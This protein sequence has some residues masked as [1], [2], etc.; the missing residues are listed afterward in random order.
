MSGLDVKDAWAD[1]L[2]RR[3]SLAPSLTAYTEL[4]ERWAD[5][6]LS[7]VP[8]AWAPSE[9]RA[10]WDR[11]IPLLAEANP[12]LDTEEVEALLGPTL[13]SIAGLR[14]GLAPGL[15]RFAE[16]WDRGAIAPATLFPRRGRLGS[17]GDEVG[18][19][20]D[21]LGFLAL[22]ALRPF[23][24]VYFSE[25][26]THLDDGVW[27]LGVCPFCGAPPGFGD[28]VEDGRR[29]LSCH[30]CGGVWTARRLWCPF[31]ANEESRQLVRLAPEAADQGYFVSACRRCRGYL[32]ELDRRV[33]W[34]GG[35]A[36]VEDWGSPHLDLVAR[37]E[38]Y[39]RLL[40]TLLEVSHGS[41]PHAG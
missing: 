31:C 8:L 40:P 24:E 4:I 34:N 2:R 7:V 32:K 3:A 36:L 15:T 30:L 18:L 41:P 16:A 9:C 29:R 23:L 37:K 21:T 10:R 26:R 28:V 12:A 5:A 1:L 38:G 27:F 33:R 17:V 13:D 25:V 6:S 11:G 20:P 35:P 22:A 14:V 39:W 19:E